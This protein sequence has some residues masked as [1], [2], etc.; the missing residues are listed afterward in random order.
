MS[1]KQTSRADNLD[2]ITSMPL[3]EARSRA[4]DFC[5]SSI[6]V[7]SKVRARCSSYR[8][9]DET[10]AEESTEESYI[11]IALLSLLGRG[12]IRLRNNKKKRHEALKRNGEPRE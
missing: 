11:L 12:D 4:L 10:I 6:S 2:I 3:L 9:G 8:D 1:E 7:T 5:T